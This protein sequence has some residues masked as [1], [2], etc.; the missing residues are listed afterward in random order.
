M[1]EVIT[2]K[3]RP[4]KCAKKIEQNTINLH[5]A[6]NDRF[7]KESDVFFVTICFVSYLENCRFLILGCGCWLRRSVRQE[8]ATGK[9]WMEVFLF[10]FTLSLA[11][12]ISSWLLLFQ[13]MT[14]ALLHAHRCMWKDEPVPVP[15][16][17]NTIP[18][19][20]VP[21]HIIVPRCSGE[22]QAGRVQIFCSRR[23]PAAFRTWN[24]F[25]SEQSNN[26]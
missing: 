11:S 24:L 6:K 17:L 22:T 21:S 3:E 2:Q 10:L 4:W 23:R 14:T 1:V 12:T 15:I 16:P 13:D 20:I 25:I 9:Y 8:G 26:W 5:D 18:D 7:S 19:M